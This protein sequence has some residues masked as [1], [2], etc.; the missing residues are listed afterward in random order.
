MMQCDM[1]RD[2]YSSILGLDFSESAVAAMMVAH[3]E[4][5]GVTYR[6][7]DCRQALRVTHAIA[8]PKIRCCQSTKHGTGLGVDR[9]D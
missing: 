7:A 9:S 6:V 4:L 5:P 3:E 2:G 1:A 8:H